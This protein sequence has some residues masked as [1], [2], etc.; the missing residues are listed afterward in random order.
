MQSVQSAPKVHIFDRR[1]SPNPHTSGERRRNKNNN[2]ALAAANANSTDFPA[3]QVLEGGLIVE[4]LQPQ[5]QLDI[6]Q[7]GE[8]RPRGN[9]RGGR[10]RGRGSR[11]GKGSNSGSGR[12]FQ[13]KEHDVQ[14]LVL[15]DQQQTPF[16]QL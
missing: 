13:K 4:G 7:D 6:A 9:Q 2:D 15:P 1:N 16:Q 5:H 3:Q 10:G 14:Q 8:A 11:S 12:L